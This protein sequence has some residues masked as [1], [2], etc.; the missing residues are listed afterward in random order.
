MITRLF[1]II[2]L[3]T[4]AGCSTTGNVE[5]ESVYSSTETR[6]LT[7]NGSNGIIDSINAWRNLAGRLSS[8]DQER[9]RQAVHFILDSKDL[10]FGTTVSWHNDKDDVHGFVTYVS[11]VGTRFHF[12]K[13]IKSIIV[14][15]T[16]RR[17]FKE[18]ACKGNGTRGWVF[19]RG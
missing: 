12:C 5:S 15:G 2:S 18:T 19:E 8:E 16:N 3:I 11:G 4:L 7:Y 1:L 17:D 10:E 13:T 9:Q 6:Y 14:K